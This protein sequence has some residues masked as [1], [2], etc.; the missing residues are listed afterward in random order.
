M[1]NHF[2]TPDSGHDLIADRAA[3][4][5]EQMKSQAFPFTFQTMDEVRSILKDVYFAV[6]LEW[7]SQATTRFAR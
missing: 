7:K 1:Y 4:I 2:F 5:I 6:V 3:V